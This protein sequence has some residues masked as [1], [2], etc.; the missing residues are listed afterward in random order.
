LGSGDGSGQTIRSHGLFIK[1][2]E[3]T[4]M[5]ISTQKVSRSAASDA[6]SA[7]IPAK[8]AFP[9]AAG[10]KPPRHRVRGATSSS[11]AKAAKKLA[12]DQKK[13]E[14]RRKVEAKRE[15]KAEKI[16]K[17]EVE[18]KETDDRFTSREFVKAIE[19][20]FGKISF[21][22]CWH[23]ASAVRP[24]AHL[25]VRKGHNGLRDPWSGQLVFVNPPWSAQ[26]KWVRRAHYHWASGNAQ[27]VVCLV[28]AKTD[29]VFFHQTLI[30]DADLYFIEGRPRFFKKDKT[31]EGTKVATMLVIFGATDQ[32]RMRLAELI[33]GTWFQPSQR[34][35]HRRREST[36]S[37]VGSAKHLGPLSCAAPSARNDAK[38]TVFCSP[39]V[40]RS[41]AASLA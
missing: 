21:D 19:Y 40:G 1:L 6:A 27:T 20:S 41:Q 34:S 33:R 4:G 35:S 8:P 10:K 38:W 31:F 9:D 25:D 23:E 3:E 17:K 5:T 24:K 15:E 32:Q 14:R 29:T 16:R 2:E 12:A 36:A 22:P 11:I 7:N 37:L 18:Q 13:E 39:S 30:E 26:D 28:P